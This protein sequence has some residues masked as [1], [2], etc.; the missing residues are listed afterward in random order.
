MYIAFMLGISRRILPCR[1]YILYIQIQV[2]FADELMSINKLRGMYVNRRDSF[3]KAV[4]LC[5]YFFYLTLFF[6][7]SLSFIIHLYPSSKFLRDC[8]YH[9]INV[10]L[11]FEAYLCLVLFVLLFAI[12]CMCLL[13]SF[14]KKPPHPQKYAPHTRVAFFTSNIPHISQFHSP[15]NR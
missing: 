9:T 8:K 2:Y 12:L 3:W 14:R 11:R 4:A 1:L 5:Y 13:Y 15:C 6:F 7:L 10:I